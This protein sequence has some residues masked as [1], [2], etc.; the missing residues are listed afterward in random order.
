[1]M[2]K[3]IINS[4]HELSTQ[5]GKKHFNQIIVKSVKML[6]FA[7]LKMHPDITLTGKSSTVMTFSFKCIKLCT[8]SNETWFQ[9]FG[10][11]HNYF[12]A[13]LSRMCRCK[14]NIRALLITKYINNQFFKK[15]DIMF[16]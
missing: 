14:S 9:K 10:D 16:T 2:T 4:K 6:P 3:Y 11:F 5:T 12:D 7:T 1:M 8:S 13:R 15:F